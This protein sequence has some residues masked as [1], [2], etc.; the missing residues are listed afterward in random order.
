[1]LQAYIPDATPLSVDDYYIKELPTGIDELVFTL[2]IWDPAYRWIA[3]ETLIED[4]EEYGVAQYRVKAI[5]GGDNTAQIKAL[6]TLD[7]WQATV[8]IDYE[9]D[10]TIA[11]NVQAVA[12]AGWTVIDSSGM[13]GTVTIA[14]AVNGTPLDLMGNFRDA[15]DGASFRFNQTAK[16]V[17][18]YDLYNGPNL[19]TFLTREL[20]LHDV[21]YKGKSTQF[22]TRLYAYGKDGLSIAEV[23]DGKP[24]VDNFTYSDRIICGYWQDT[25]YE[26]AD[27][28]K[29][30]AIAH[31]AEIAVPERSFNCSVADLASID[32]DKYSYLSFTLFSQVGLIDETRSEQKIMHRVVE[33]WRYPN[34]PEK[35]NVILSNSP[36]RIQVQVVQ[37]LRGPINGNRIESSSIGSGKIGGGAILESKIAPSAVTVNKIRDGAVTTIKIQDGAVTTA[38]VLNEAITLAKMWPDFQVFYADIIAALAIFSDYVKVNG[39]L[40][41]SV[42]Y[43]RSNYIVMG[44]VG[45]SEAYAPGTVNDHLYTLI[46]SWSGSTDS[47]GDYYE[48]PTYSLSNNLTS[49]WTTLIRRNIE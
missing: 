4:R 28:L 21:Q 6:L 5:D 45:S 10:G 35:N 2:S 33:R 49:S 8:K 41:C 40:E 47:N 27:N 16:T 19:G 1:M 42:L 12:P 11:Q 13:T 29:E 43:V 20:N 7:D 22:V 38:K 32:P 48:Y 23:N 34:Y 3:E 14:D 9:I 24:Y 37:A 31:L 39:A 25:R 18:I 15:F 30:A 46:E 44:S 26:V 36:H 17:T